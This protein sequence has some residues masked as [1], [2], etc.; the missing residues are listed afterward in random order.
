M[1]TNAL[2]AHV[3]AQT[4]ELGLAELGTLTVQA[5]SRSLRNAS[6]RQMA[7]PLSGSE[8]P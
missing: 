1:T 4:N 5:A 7:R 2:L 3:K 6:D 8:R